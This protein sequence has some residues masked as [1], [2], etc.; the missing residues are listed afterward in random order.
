MQNKMPAAQMVPI[1]W[2]RRVSTMTAKEEGEGAG[3]PSP[4]FQDEVAT[5]LPLRS[6]S[7]TTTTTPTTAATAAPMVHM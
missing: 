6:N 7:V 1:N 5:F 2:Q 3:T 4:T